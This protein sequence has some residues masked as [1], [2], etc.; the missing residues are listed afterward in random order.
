MSGS[1]GGGGGQL[2]VTDTSFGDDLADGI[3]AGNDDTTSSGADTLVPTGDAQQLDA[4]PTDTLQSADV[5]MADTALADVGISD[6]TDALVSAD[7]TANNDTAN[8]A[9]ADAVADTSALDTA[10]SDGASVAPD[11]TAQ[12]DGGGAS[13][14][15]DDGLPYGGKVGSGCSGQEGVNTCSSGWK[16]R[17]ICINGVWTSQQ[18]C[19]FGLCKRFKSAG[20][21]VVSQC[22]VPAAKNM[23]LAKA[24]SQYIKCFQPPMSLE[25]C[26][27]LNL[28]RAKI[29]GQMPIG[30]VRDV[31]NL[32]AADLLG[33]IKCA[34]HTK[35]CNALAECLHWFAANKCVK[36]T[37]SGCDGDLAWACLGKT[38]PLAVACQDHGLKCALLNGKATCAKPF[39]CLS[40][41]GGKCTGDIAQECVADDKGK[42]LGV[43]SDCATIGMTCVATPQTNSAGCGKPTKSCTSKFISKCQ[44]GDAINCATSTVI[45]RKCGVAQTCMYEGQLKRLFTKCPSDIICPA[46]HCSEGGNCSQPTFCSGTL[47]NYCEGGQPASVDCK[48]LGMKCITSKFGARCQ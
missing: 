20:G 27:R 9:A 37:S 24:C 29:A 1:G 10:P 4:Q 22:Y 44:A 2:W 40:K 19:G 6:Q 48:D 34:A 23:A 38:K 42:L 33:A 31:L 12:S 43:T 25:D 21:A 16:H 14:D 15:T 11:T 3:G 35:S 18:H 30:Q 17:V 26:V 8:N 46:T 36:T 47:V 39:I 45:K 13:S 5:S 32:A 7:D 41:G 28:H